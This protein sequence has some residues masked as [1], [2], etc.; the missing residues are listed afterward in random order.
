[1]SESKIEH[2]HKFDKKFIESGCTDNRY[3]WMCECGDYIYGGE[4][5]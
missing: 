3:Y 1:M 2:K 4:V 5:Q